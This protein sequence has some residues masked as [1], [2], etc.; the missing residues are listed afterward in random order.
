MTKYKFTVAAFYENI[1]IEAD[2]EEE[3]KQIAIM[4][5]QDRWPDDI[6]AATMEGEDGNE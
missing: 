2:Y 6:V 1:T 5:I 3:A 4:T